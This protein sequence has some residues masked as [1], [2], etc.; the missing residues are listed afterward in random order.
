MLF[1]PWA[2]SIIP[3]WTSS[4]LSAAVSPPF[5]GRPVGSLSAPTTGPAEVAL[6]DFD[7]LM[8]DLTESDGSVSPLVPVKIPCA[9]LS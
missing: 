6:N 3:N 8:N 1:F 7:L 2:T 4:L 5:L 9:L